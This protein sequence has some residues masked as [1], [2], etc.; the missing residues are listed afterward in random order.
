MDQTDPQK[1]KRKS[2]DASGSSGEDAVAAGMSSVHESDRSQAQREGW[3]SVEEN[4]AM[5]RQGDAAGDGKPN[6]VLREW[7]DA[8]RISRNV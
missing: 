2:G 1:N 8:S 6:G 3:Q 7:P 4:R 5:E